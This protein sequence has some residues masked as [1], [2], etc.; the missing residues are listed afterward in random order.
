MKHFLFCCLAVG[1]A[2]L[3]PSCSSI[4]GIEELKLFKTGAEVS[5]VWGDDG[6]PLTKDL[7]NSFVEK[8][9]SPEMAKYLEERQKA[10][11]IES[12]DLI[13]E[14][15]SIDSVE[16][17]MDPNTSIEQSQVFTKDGLNLWLP[18]LDVGAHNIVTFENGSGASSF[19]N[20]GE[21]NIRVSKT[22]KITVY[23]GLTASVY[24][25]Q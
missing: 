12:K 8:Q 11:M 25:K 9:M 23:P 13:I 7:S 16:V 20:Y 22:V 4:L 17:I 3:L 19:K 18:T 6:S 2:L 24:I 5:I 21:F 14:E 10:K 1:L 15:V